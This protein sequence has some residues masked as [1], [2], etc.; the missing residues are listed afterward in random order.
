MDHDVS[1]SYKHPLPYPLLTPPGKKPTQWEPNYSPSLNICPDRCAALGGEKSHLRLTAFTRTHQIQAAHV[2][3][4]QEP[5]SDALILHSTATFS[6]LPQAP[7]NSIPLCPSHWLPTQQEKEEKK[8]IKPAER[9]SL[10]F[11]L[12]NLQTYA[13]TSLNDGDLALVQVN[14]SRTIR[15]CPAEFNMPPCLSC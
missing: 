8:H 15:S 9:N 2:P 1:G 14:C 3:T 11:T 5:F 4:F 7:Q 12:S 6:K 10:N 13:P